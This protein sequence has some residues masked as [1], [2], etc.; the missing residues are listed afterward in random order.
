MLVRCRSLHYNCSSTLHLTSHSLYI[1]TI[2]FWFFIRKNLAA[3][4]VQ[5]EVDRMGKGKVIMKEP[6]KIFSAFAP[7]LN[8]PV[9]RD[10]RFFLMPPSSTP[11]KLKVKVGKNPYAD[12]VNPHFHPFR[13]KGKEYVQLSPKEKWTATISDMI[14]VQN[15][16]KL[17]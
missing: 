1:L 17:E 15:R 13:G 5:W 3:A 8:Q 4:M 16:G 6:M 14:R 7:A 9:P 12:S 11:Q 10:D 2:C